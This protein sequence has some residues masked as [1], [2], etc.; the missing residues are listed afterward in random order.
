MLVH[1]HL[2]VLLGVLQV[3][4]QVVLGPLHTR[5]LVGSGVSIIRDRAGRAAHDAVEVGA[6]LVGASLRDVSSEPNHGYPTVHC[7]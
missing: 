5:S 7:H 3:F 4:E 6:L 1:T 2:D